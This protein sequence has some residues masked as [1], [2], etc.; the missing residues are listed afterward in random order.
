MQTIDK[1]EWSLKRE[2]GRIGRPSTAAV[3]MCLDSL[4]TEV[5]PNIE[6]DLCFRGHQ[7]CVSVKLG[8]E[9]ESAALSKDQPAL[10]ENVCHETCSWDLLSGRLSS[11]GRDKLWP[12]KFT[13]TH[14]Q[15]L[16]KV[17]VWVSYWFHAMHC[18][19]IHPAISLVGRLIRNQKYFKCS[20][21]A[22][23]LLTFQERS[24]HLNI[25][26][27]HRGSSSVSCSAC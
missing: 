9:D 19:Q 5:D 4:F 27:R 14:K 3:P 18:K 10:S 1:I 22:H 21:L 23:Y 25:L 16:N 24:T 7:R 20:C 8:Y 17:S 26:L 6:S 15:L 11:R 12:L 13:W 2:K